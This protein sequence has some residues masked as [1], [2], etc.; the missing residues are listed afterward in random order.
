MLT[1]IIY[2]CQLANE[3]PHHYLTA[4]QEYSTEVNQNPEQWLPWNYQ[5][6]LKTQLEQVE[7]ANQQEDKLGQAPL[8]E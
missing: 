5:A 6:S 7:L 4:L 3:N 2:T 1:S 8:A